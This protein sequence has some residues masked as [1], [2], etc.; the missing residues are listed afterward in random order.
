MSN[1]VKL[2]KQVEKAS[3]PLLREE[4]KHIFEN[5]LTIMMLVDPQTGRILAANKSAVDFYKYPKDKLLGMTIFEI[6]I[7]S[8]EEILERM[9]QVLADT[10]G[11]YIFNHKLAD[12]SIKTVRVHSSKI[13]I[14][15]ESYIFSV[16]YDNTDLI[17]LENE[18]LTVNKQL[19]DALI[20]NQNLIKNASEGIIVY[21]KDL[22]YTVW[23]NFM[24]KTTGLEAS[25]VLGKKTTEIFSQGTYSDVT[26]GLK[27]ALMG[28]VVTLESVEF[29]NPVTKVSGYT[30]EVY[31]PNYDSEGN[32]IG[33]VCIISDV[34]SIVEYQKSLARKNKE[35]EELNK[36]LSSKMKE[37]ETAKNKAEES[38][39]LKSAFL[40]HVSHEIRTPLNSIVGF[41]N[42]LR[43]VK[44]PS[45]VTDYSYII[46]TNNLYLLNIIENILTFALIESNSVLLHF[47]ELDLITLL[48]NLAN[49][50]KD[51]NS[52]DLRLRLETQGLDKFLINT[53]ESKVNQILTNFLTNALKF[54]KYGDINFG[55]KKYDKN[56]ITLFVSDPGLG[57]DPKNHEVIFD[58]FFKLDTLIAGSGLG[59]SICRALSE[60]L[61]GKIYLESELGK[62]ATFYFEIAYRDI[63]QGDN[64]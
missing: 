27:R 54:T 10:K 45:L 19:K 51:A 58:R 14:D 43:D 50:F 42:L 5:N 32:I 61:G 15:E 55:I 33:V 31:S 62:G 1:P 28:E 41:S 63:N 37:L 57:I 36:L 30:R 7:M 17:Q 24:A 22:K 4:C 3:S 47:E 59:L 6:N 60:M 2:V 13:V 39:R 25:K 34:T 29:V 20:F 12:D 64:K 26:D 23:N 56:T 49:N 35:L 11:N 21:D 38:D 8:Q 16:I 9:G 40:A 18:H 44:K 48:R 46:N 52:R 53:D